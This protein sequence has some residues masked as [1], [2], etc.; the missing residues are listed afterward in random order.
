M[1]GHQVV[2]AAGAAVGEASIAVEGHRVTSSSLDAALAWVQA[3]DAGISAEERKRAERSMRFLRA[4]LRNPYPRQRIV[5]IRSVVLAVPAIALSVY[6]VVLLALVIREAPSAIP[7][8]ATRQ[9]VL[10]DATGTFVW[11]LTIALACSLLL[12]LAVP[13]ALRVILGIVGAFCLLYGL[14]MQPVAYGAVDADAGSAVFATLAFG[15]LFIV[16]WAIGGRR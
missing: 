11:P 16:T 10:E 4:R 6:L 15:V 2:N 9:S 5:D 3:P 7:P 8:G 13:R 12:T 1:T 14:I